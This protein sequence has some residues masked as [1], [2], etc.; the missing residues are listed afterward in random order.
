MNG[1]TSTTCLVEEGVIKVAV[2]E[3]RVTKL[4]K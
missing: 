2:S 1:H 4:K 3:E